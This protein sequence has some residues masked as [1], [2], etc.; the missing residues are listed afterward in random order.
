MAKR[1]NKE[2][3]LN[4]IQAELERLEKQWGFVR[5]NGYDQVKGSDFHRIMAYGA[6]D[7]LQELD[8]AIWF[9]NLE[10]GDNE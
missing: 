7:A 2:N 1:F 6:Y 4:H 9:G 10:G 3:V 5:D 8:S